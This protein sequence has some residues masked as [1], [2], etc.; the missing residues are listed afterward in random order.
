[1]VLETKEKI[2]RMRIF[3]CK[4]KAI[5]CNQF[6]QII[7]L[8]SLVAFVFW[9]GLWGGAP[10][11][12]QLPYLHQISQFTNLW[13][14]LVNSPSWNRTQSAGD[15]MLFRPI[16][17]WQLGLFYYFFGYDFFYWQ[18][19]SLILHLLVVIGLYR[20]LVQGKL[21]NTVYP[22]LITALFGCA[23][24]SSEL[25]LWNHISGY[26]TFSLFSICA[27]LYVIKFL[28][29]KN[30][31]FGY[32]ALIFSVLAE[33]TYELGVVLIGLIIITLFYNYRYGFV[34]VAIKKAYLILA[35]S[36]IGVLALYPVLSIL[37]LVMR[38]QS[39]SSIGGSSTVYG[40]LFAFW[41]ALKQ[42]AFW[43]WA[44]LFPFGYD[45]RSDGRAVFDGFHLFG[46]NFLV[47]FAILILVLGFLLAKIRKDFF[48]SLV[49]NKERWLSVSLTLVFLFT[50]SFVIAYG[51]SVPRGIDYVLD[52]NI[53][54]AYIAF[55]SVAIGL[56]LCF[57]GK[58]SEST[59]LVQ[60][61]AGRQSENHARVTNFSIL[62]VTLLCLIAFN[63]R[64]TYE[65]ASSYRYNFSPPIMEV[66]DVV[67]NFMHADKYEKSYFIVEDSCPGNFKLP[68][69][70]R[71]HYRR[72]SD[73]FEPA[74][75]A[76][77][78]FPEHSFALNKNEL[79]EK[80]VDLIE[81]YCS[82][83]SATSVL[84]NYDASKLTVAGDPGWHAATPAA[85]PQ[86]LD[87]DLGYVRKVENVYF[88][89]QKELTQRFPHAIAI[90]ASNNK[91]EWKHLFKGELGCGE[92]S[93]RWRTVR[94]SSEHNIRYMRIYILSN[95][96]DPTYLTLKGLRFD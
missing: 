39:L 67:E 91:N 37:D 69:F 22:L 95:C 90:Q 7:L 53:Y 17:Y 29:T 27:I 16:L 59:R 73:W 14:I 72:S 85:Y 33:F 89:P 25:V 38:G 56:A 76:D 66:I 31:L 78:L 74:T 3:I 21:K 13:D 26:I 63:A 55:L 42:I 44:W 48:Y 83:V 46:T 23:F 6:I 20:L 11:A 8:S 87:V 57:I 28:K 4:Y 5:L 68:W 62:V 94:M 82:K 40:L 2:K 93:R 18:L 35:L 86:I 10:R 9:N 65:L 52:M 96:G 64:S 50:Y 34:S 15:F 84:N 12:D 51:R 47:N 81:I 43:L 79:S 92:S 77:V 24:F 70:D 41:Y 71:G 60:D 80:N 88:L 45:I 36:Y 19:A 61:A 75:I 49:E 1:M 32:I 58:K 54:Y 30:V